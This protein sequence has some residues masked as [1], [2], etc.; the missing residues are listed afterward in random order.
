MRFSA[1]IE[2]AGIVIAGLFLEG[3]CLA[4]CPDANVS[5]EL[6][7]RN[8]LSR[9]R[10]PLERIDW[11]SMQGGHS[12]IRGWYPP[13]PRRTS[14]SHVHAFD[15]NYSE[16]N[17]RMKGDNLPLATDLIPDPDLVGDFLPLC[18]RIL[19]IVNMDLVLIPEWEYHLFHGYGEQN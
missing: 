2:I 10:T 18:G 19:N 5:I 3:G 16:T 6:V 4:D 1:P 11:R 17:R 15:L 13:L 12:N 7:Y 14:S 8:P 9:G